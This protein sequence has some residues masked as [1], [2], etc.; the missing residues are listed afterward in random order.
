MMIFEN[1]G[2]CESAETRVI[3]TTMVK[4]TVLSRNNN[5]EDND[6]TDDNDESESN[7]TPPNTPSLMKEMQ[8]VI[9]RDEVGIFTLEVDEPK[10]DSEIDDNE[11]PNDDEKKE[12]LKQVPEGNAKEDNQTE[13]EEDVSDSESTSTIGYTRTEQTERLRDLEQ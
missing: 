12:E 9:A 10:P 5:T 11:K 8:D 1:P 4:E 2:G 13:E 7:K 6:V 3:S